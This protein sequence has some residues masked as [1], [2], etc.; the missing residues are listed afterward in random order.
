MSLQSHQ[1]SS[2]EGQNNQ[3]TFPGKSHTQLQD[4]QEGGAGELQ[5][6]QQNLVVLGKI[7]EQILLEA[8]VKYTKDKKV[9]ENGQ[10]GFTGG[11]QRSPACLP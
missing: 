2:S 7:V 4:R 3:G 5:A 10:C 9:I 11:E 8:V 1:L 6:G